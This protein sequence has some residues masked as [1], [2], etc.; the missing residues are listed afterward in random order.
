MKSS[1]KEALITLIWHVAAL[2]FACVITAISVLM[3]IEHRMPPFGALTPFAA[4][5]ESA[6]STRQSDRPNLSVSCDDGK[7][8]ITTTKS[9]GFATT[10]AVVVDGQ[11]VDCGMTYKVNGQEI[12]ALTVLQHAMSN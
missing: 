6:V 2:V 11:F 9:G 10:S 12:S 8:F 5:T 7:A 4:L 1:R 3:L